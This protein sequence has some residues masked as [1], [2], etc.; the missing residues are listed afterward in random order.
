MPPPPPMSR[1]SQAPIAV[2][3]AARLTALAL[4]LRVSLALVTRSAAC[5][6]LLIRLSS[7]AF[8]VQTGQKPEP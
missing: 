8:P 5:C 2:V 1:T 6:Q 3:K 7:S 4:Y